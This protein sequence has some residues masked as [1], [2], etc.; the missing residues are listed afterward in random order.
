MFPVQWP[1][2]SFWT[3]PS[4]CIMMGGVWMSE[5]DLEGLLEANDKVMNITQQFWLQVLIYFSSTTLKWFLFL[6]SW[7]FLTYRALIVDNKGHLISQSLNMTYWLDSFYRCFSRVNVQFYNSIIQIHSF[8][9]NHI[10]ILPLLSFLALSRWFLLPYPNLF[11]WL[12][13]QLCSF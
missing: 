1:T 8:L 7:W 6:Y 9:T 13:E 12:W 2:E 3:W 4:A 10:E 11:N 5:W